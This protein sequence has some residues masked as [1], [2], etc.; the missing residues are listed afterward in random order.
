MDATNPK[1]IENET[2]IDEWERR[3]QEWLQQ[4]KQ[5]QAS[6]RAAGGKVDP[7]DV[8]V[9]FGPPMT[10]EEFRAWQTRRQKALKNFSQQ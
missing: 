10:E 2:P 4:A 5:G 6:Q 3:T 7:K 8:R 1:K 9:E